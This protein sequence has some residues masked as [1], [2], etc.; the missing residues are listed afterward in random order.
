[1]LLNHKVTCIN[2]SGMHKLGQTLLGVNPAILKRSGQEMSMA[3]LRL[4]LLV[5]PRSGHG[6]DS[7]YLGRKF[8]TIINILHE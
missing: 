4:T 3:Y 1:M 6:L 5:R 8:Y 2:R 7:T